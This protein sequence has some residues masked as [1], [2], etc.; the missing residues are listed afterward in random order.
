MP[1]NIRSQVFAK[2]AYEKVS[3]VAGGVHGVSAADY[4]RHC[5]KFPLL[6]RS[7][8]LMEVVAFARAKGAGEGGL[9]QAYARYIQDLL[10][11][12]GLT[13][14]AIR[15]CPN[16]ETYMVYSAR[17]MEIAGWFKRYAEA[18]LGEG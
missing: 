9:A 2:S 18:T 3:A 5:R 4:G 12:A 10:Q 8:G 13:E 6:I 17:A 15:T 16:A 11:A 1:V 7:C 14:E